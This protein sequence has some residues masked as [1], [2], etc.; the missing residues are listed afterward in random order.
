MFL[1]YP[2]HLTDLEM[3]VEDINLSTET[4]ASGKGPISSEYGTDIDKNTDIPESTGE[5]ET[6][7]FFS[8]EDKLHII[9]YSDSDVSVSCR[10]MWIRLG[11]IRDVSVEYEF[12]QPVLC[13]GF[14][15]VALFV[16]AFLH[17][18]IDL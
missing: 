11:I 6:N 7:D 13:A 1:C 4:E 3:K 17:T 5:G 16:H 18:K 15:T 9:Q 10:L 12:S 14:V 2:S 8:G